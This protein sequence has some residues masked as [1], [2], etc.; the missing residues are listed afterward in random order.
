MDPDGFMIVEYTFHS[1]SNESSSYLSSQTANTPLCVR[2]SIIVTADF[3]KESL[4]K[5]HIL[6]I[7]AEEIVHQPPQVF[8]A[9]SIFSVHIDDMRSIVERLVESLDTAVNHIE[10]TVAV[11]HVVFRDEDDA[12]ISHNCKTPILCGFHGSPDRI[13]NLLKTARTR[14]NAELASILQNNSQTV[15][16]TAEWIHRFSCSLTHKRSP[17]Y[18]IEPSATDSPAWITSSLEQFM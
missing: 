5:S 7:N 12:V 17:S 8:R 16:R 4:N 3:S 2:R 14:I 9:V 10:G 6:G 1:L 18:F 15:V 13:P 11:Q